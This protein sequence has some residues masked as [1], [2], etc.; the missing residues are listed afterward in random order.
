[1][2]VAETLMHRPDLLEQWVDP[3]VMLGFAGGDMNS[4]IQAAEIVQYMNEDLQEAFAQQYLSGRAETFKR[5]LYRGKAKSADVGNAWF[6]L[7]GQLRDLEWMQRTVHNM[8]F[9]AQMMHP[10]YIYL[11]K[12]A[13]R[14]APPK[15]GDSSGNTPLDGY[16][17]AAVL[18]V[19]FPALLELF[20]PEE[21]LD[22]GRKMI[23]HDR[24]SAFAKLKSAFRD[25][26]FKYDLLCAEE[27]IHK[28]HLEHI[29]NRMV[30]Y[31]QGGSA[32]L[33]DMT[34]LFK[35]K[36]GMHIETYADQH[37]FEPAKTVFKR[38]HDTLCSNTR[39]IGDEYYVELV[40]AALNMMIGK[41]EGYDYAILPDGPRNKVPSFAAKIAKRQ[42]ED[43]DMIRYKTR[44]GA[45]AMRDYFKNAR[46]GVNTYRPT[47]PH[48]PFTAQMKLAGPV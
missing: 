14:M 40:R 24:L 10:D 39:A 9:L 4:Y 31:H 28:M 43:V 19:G 16:A 20:E 17:E 32:C 38:W 8:P 11:M 22:M 47:K 13:L 41:A 42:L 36:G 18:C 46:G 30:M 44:K 7:S 12:E 5:I 2:H 25:E 45:D 33:L 35:Q 34:L 6:S 3:A 26:P 21:V 48:A 27:A 37:A 15:Y 29:P 23:A 1:V